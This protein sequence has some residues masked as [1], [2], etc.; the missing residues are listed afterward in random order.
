M[1]QLLPLLQRPTVPN[2]GLDA[3]DLLV[4]LTVIP[5]DAGGHLIKEDV[6]EQTGCTGELAMSIGNGARELGLLFVGQL[7]AVDEL[8][9]ADLLAEGDG[10][11]M[12]GHDLTLEAVRASVPGS[13]RR[14]L[15]RQAAAV[16]LAGGALPVEVATQ[17]ADS[18]APGDE[19]AITTL[20]KA[21][22][23]LGATDPGAGADLSQRAL[24]LAPRRHRLRRPL[25]AQ[26]AVWLH[27]GGR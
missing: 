22:E 3:S 13:V 7:T 21:A 26:T 27:A 25:V 18:A 14:S 8:I 1:G 20:C 2:G 9:H 24:E 15:D 12:F 16:L 23:T 17:L 5:G 6:N 11:L 19:V 10:R 4:W